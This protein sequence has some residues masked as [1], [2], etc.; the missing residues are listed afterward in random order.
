MKTLEELG[1]FEARFQEV[2]ETVAG[3]PSFKDGFVSVE[4]DTRI[5]Q[6]K[7]R[8]NL[9]DMD[10]IKIFM[11]IELVQKERANG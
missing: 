11:Q 9:D 6:L 4:Q 5:K 7:L 3:E 2:A 1:E 8:H 10:L